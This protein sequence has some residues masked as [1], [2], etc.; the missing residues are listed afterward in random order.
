MSEQEIF[1]TYRGAAERV[2]RD[3]R[4]I[5]RWAREW[6]AHNELGTDDEGRRVVAHSTLMRT[7]AA[8]LEAN[9]AHQRKLA[10]I[11]REHADG[12]PS[13]PA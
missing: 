11:L 2:D 10:R 5:Q 13:D 12:A 6:E 8:K 3:V 1:Y 7:L 9:S 4:T